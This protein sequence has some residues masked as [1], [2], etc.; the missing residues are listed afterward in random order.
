LFQ[1]IKYYHKKNNYLLK[2][3]VGGNWTVIIKFN[4]LF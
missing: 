3:S 1:H 2:F 4:F